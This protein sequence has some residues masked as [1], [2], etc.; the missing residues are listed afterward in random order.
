MTPRYVAICFEDTHPYRWAAA[1]DLKTAE[2]ICEGVSL[3]NID[4]R[5]G[6]VYDLDTAT[7]LADDDWDMAR[8]RAAADERMAFLVARRRAEQQATA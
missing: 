5:C 8:M 7:L 6:Y 4:T 1:A 2:A 3:C